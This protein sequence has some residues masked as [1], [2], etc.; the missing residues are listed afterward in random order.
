[1]KE[2]DR[3]AQ[4]VL[5]R[6]RCLVSRTCWE[7]GRFANRYDSRS[8]LLRLWRSRSWKRVLEVLEDSEALDRISRTKGA[9]DVCYESTDVHD[10]LSWISSNSKVLECSIDVVY[11]SKCLALLPCISRSAPGDL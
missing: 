6:V 9:E 8:I 7:N 1:M 5:E 2:G 10:W 3:I 4:L 11:L